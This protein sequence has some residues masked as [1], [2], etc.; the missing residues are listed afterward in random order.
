M[1]GPKRAKVVVALPLAQ[2]LLDK[3]SEYDL[4]VLPPEGFEPEA[5]RTALVD[6]EGVLVSSN[7]SVDRDVIASTRRLRVISTMSVGIDHID[8]DLARERGI[9][10]TITPVLANAVADLAIALMIMLSRRI[11][12]GMRAVAGGRWNE[13]SLGGDLANKELLIVGFGRIGQAVATRALAM[14]MRARY[15]D[16]RSG[17][18]VVAGVERTGALGEGLRSADFVS[19][20]VDLNEETRN[21]MGRAEF[22]VMKPTAFFV[23]TSR[24]GTADQAALAWALTEGEIAGAGL[25]VLQDEPPHPGDLLLEA[26]NTIIV[27]HIG[28][29]TRETRVAMAQCAVDNL[30]MGLRQ[31]GSPFLAPYGS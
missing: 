3:L 16:V 25:D 19:L 6:A 31:E 13:V 15:F 18:P 9:M 20:H 24:G 5:L 1:A 2:S 17:L 30:L 29:A 22:T 11:P 26:P 4:T 28:S 12:E 8:L 10:V 7:V 23:N 21:F 27:P 14:G